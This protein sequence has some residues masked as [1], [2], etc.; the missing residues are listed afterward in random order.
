MVFRRPLFLWYYEKI[1][2]NGFDLPEVA[3]KLKNFRNAKT[4]TWVI[5]ELYHK[6][7]LGYSDENIEDLPCGEKDC[8][9]IL[10]SWLIDIPLL[11]AI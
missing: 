11:I 3:Q 4:D 6:I 5:L 2:E 1:S 8:L 7:M 9:L 10:L